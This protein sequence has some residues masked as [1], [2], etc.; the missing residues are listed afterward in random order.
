[1]YNLVNSTIKFILTNRHRNILMCIEDEKKKFYQKLKQ[2][3]GKRFD[4]EKITIDFT[5]NKYWLKRRV[6]EVCK[7]YNHIGI[8]YHEIKILGALYSGCFVQIE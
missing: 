3:Y 5:F 6:F 8:L 4:R 2:L 1:M 7:K